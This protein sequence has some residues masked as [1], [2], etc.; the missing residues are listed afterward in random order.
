M[1][2]PE[3]RA[4]P[5]P[6]ADLSAPGESGA[7]TALKAELAD[8]DRRIFS[9]EAA[10]TQ[11]ETDIRT[12]EST[13]AAVYASTT[14]KL[15]APLRVAKRVLG[16]IANPAR[17]R[18]LLPDRPFDLPAAVHAEPAAN[19]PEWQRRRLAERLRAPSP[20]S[21]LWNHL[22]TVVVFAD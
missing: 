18:E 15:G 20:A 9:L 4:A 3:D 14:W 17:H 5:S 12:L 10:L 22:I 1:S 16:R 19:Y 7:L 11:R 6:S 2:A 13:L 8:K 21:G